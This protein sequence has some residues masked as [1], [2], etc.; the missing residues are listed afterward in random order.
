MRWKNSLVTPISKHNGNKSSPSSYRPI[1]LTSTVSRM[2]ESIIRDRLFTCLKDN[3]I[4][5]DKQYG[6]LSGRSTVLQ[7]LTVID[8]DKK[9][10][11]GS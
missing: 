8:K 6:C 1:S 9:H 11:E 10:I 5:T 2:M 3:E 4:L 7:L